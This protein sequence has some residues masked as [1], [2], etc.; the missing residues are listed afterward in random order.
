MD[1]PPLVRVEDSG[2]E[3]SFKVIDAVHFES[4]KINLNFFLVK[5]LIKK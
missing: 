5:W 2:N 1:G 4:E 3:S